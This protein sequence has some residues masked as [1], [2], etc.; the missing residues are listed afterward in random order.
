MKLGDFTGEVAARGR[1]EHQRN[2][3][4]ADRWWDT[5]PFMHQNDHAGPKTARDPRHQMLRR[6]RPAIPAS[7][8]PTHALQP[9]F[10]ECSS[11]E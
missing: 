6:F 1:L 7:H 4:D 9:S 8:A 5:W 11:Q 10:L 3:F 2:A